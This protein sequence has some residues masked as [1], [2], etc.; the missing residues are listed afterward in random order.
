MDSC[1]DIRVTLK[2][3]AVNAVIVTFNRKELL[4]RCIQAILNQTYSVKN[5]VI[6]DNAST[7]GTD[8]LLK[9]L[10]YLDNEKILYRR[11]STNIGGAGGFHEGMKF[12]HS[13]RQDWCWIMDDDVI[14]A[15]D[16]LEELVV[17][18][19]VVD[20]NMIKKVLKIGCQ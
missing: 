4:E 13:L 19:K 14:P 15:T 10:D 2:Q 11:L 20:K 8:K 9:E 3:V 1:N 12:A 18:S 17:V 6:I 5:I 16:C 7:D